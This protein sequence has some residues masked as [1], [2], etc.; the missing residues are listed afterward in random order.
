MADIKVKCQH[1][2]TCTSTSSI[3]CDECH[4]NFCRKHSLE[5]IEKHEIIVR[6]K[7]QQ[8][9]D[10]T[11][12]FKS[13][14]NTIQ[15]ET[16]NAQLPL[17][18]WKDSLIEQIEDIYKRK[19]HEIAEI[20]KKIVKNIDQMNSK[21]NNR[22]L[23]KLNELV[24]QEKNLYEHDLTKVEC[25]LNELKSIVDKWEKPLIEIK[26]DQIK[27][28]GDMRIT[29]NSY[30]IEEDEDDFHSVCDEE[31]CTSLPTCPEI[32]V[33]LTNRL[34]FPPFSQLSDVNDPSFTYYHFDHRGVCTPFI[35]WCFVGEIIDYGFIF[36]PRFMLRDIDDKK[37]PV[38][39][40]IEEPIKKDLLQKCI[41]KCMLILY[42]EQHYFLDLSC[43]IRVECPT[44]VKIISCSLKQLFDYDKERREMLTASKIKCCNRLWLSEVE[45]VGTQVSL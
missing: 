43:G 30:K 26:C 29:V 24:K 11:N 41:G 32:E 39:F 33:C 2:Q 18:K 9:M 37:V 14:L 5:H 1:S 15:N 20:Q 7:L 40:Y 27:L 35:S 23:M 44:A 42:G 10:E 21:L 34:Y 6:E 28:I 12:A 19:S 4:L 45:L 38:H 8:L 17:E 36:R 16:M 13:C 22:V 31:N 25:N 3:T